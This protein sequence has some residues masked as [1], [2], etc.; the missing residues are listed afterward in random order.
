MCAGLAAIHAA[1]VVHRALEPAN[2]L[3]D[4]SGR[5]AIADFGVALSTLGDEPMPR[6]RS[7]DHVRPPSIQELVG[8]VAGR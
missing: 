5:V 6:E 4:R 2:V 7:C 3:L 1:D 8:D